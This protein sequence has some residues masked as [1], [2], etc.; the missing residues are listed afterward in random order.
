MST[1]AI[2]LLCIFA[3]IG[4]Y[5]IIAVLIIRMIFKKAKRPNYMSSIFVLSIVLVGAIV[6]WILYQTD[7]I[8]FTSALM[9]ILFSSIVARHKRLQN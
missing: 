9:I 4:F 3:L 5:A 7:F 8:P 6:D 2:A 1:L